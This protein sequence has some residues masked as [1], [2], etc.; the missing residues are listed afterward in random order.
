MEMFQERYIGLRSQY[1]FP[2][3]DYSIKYD[4]LNY[5][6]IKEKLKT[7]IKNISII[8]C[9]TYKIEFDKE[10]LVKGIIADSEFFLLGH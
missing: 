1:I 10:D 9:K 7:K 5:N 8:G 6:T 3:K 4:K 2:L